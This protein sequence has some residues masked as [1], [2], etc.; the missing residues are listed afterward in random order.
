MDPRYG[1]G[2]W[3]RVFYGGHGERRGTARRPHP[4]VR[5]IHPSHFSES[6]SRV[7]GEGRGATKPFVRVIFSSQLSEPVIRV[8]Y[9]SHQSEVIRVSTRVINPSPLARALVSVSIRVS[10]RVLSESLSESFI[11]VF[12]RVI[13]PSHLSES[14]SESILVRALR[15]PLPLA[16]SLAL[17]L[18]R[19]RVCVG[20]CVCVRAFTKRT[21][22]RA[23][24][25]IVECASCACFAWSQYI[26]IL[27]DR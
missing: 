5:V 24:S 19:A 27:H 11:R 15:Y 6:F 1:P 7:V 2:S 18:A 16:L 23:R 12:I 26:Y 8:I 10:V 3:A 21:C 13:Y 25:W 22:A 9:P 14:L 17:S 20:A 4:F